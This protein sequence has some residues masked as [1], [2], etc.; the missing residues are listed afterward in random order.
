[1]AMLPPLILELKSR[2][3]EVITDLKGVDAAVSKTEAAVNSSASGIE[4]G[5]NRV[6]AAGKIVGVG[7]LAAGLVVGGVSLKMATDFQ[8]HMTL[9]QTAAGETKSGVKVVSDG[10]LN[11]AGA[12]GTSIDQLSDGAYVIE[13]AG[14]RGAAAIDVLRAASE[15]AKAENVDLATSTNALTS[16]MMSYHLRASDAV[17]TENELVAAS[18]QAKTTM[19]A[20][21][22]AL[23]T[24]I[25]VAS[26][27][28]IGFDQVG[29]AIATLTQHGTSADE[30]TQELANTIRNLQSPNAVA[31][32]A[33]QQLG[34][35]SVDVS[36]K[37]GQRGL[38]GTIDLVYDAIAKKMGPSGLVVVDTMKKSAAAS[39][40]LQ[41]MLGKMP[42]QLQQLSQSYLDGKVGL[43]DYQKSVKGMDNTSASMGLQFLSV[44]KNAD[45]FNNMI[46]AGNPAALTFSGYLKQVMGGATG[47][48]T[49][50]MLGGEN[51]AG[52]KSRVEDVSNAAKHGGKDISTWAQTQKNLSVQLDQAKEAAAAMGV[53]IGTVLIPYVSQ[54]IRVGAQWMQ[55]LQKHPAVLISIASV[56][57]GVLLVAIAAYVAKITWAAAQ[58]VVSFARMTAA[59]VVWIAKQTASA[60]ES[61]AIWSMYAGEWIATQ[62][63]AA[64]EWVGLWLTYGPAWIAEQATSVGESIAL[65]GM[66]AADW[67][68]A[69]AS[70]VAESVALWGMFAAEWVAKQSVSVAESVALW[71]MYA[72]Q[73][74][75]KQATA[76]A[77]GTAQWAVFYARWVAQAA[78]G[79]ARWVAAQSVAFAQATAR[80]AAFA[81]A[82]VAQGAGQAA[83][84]VASTA[85]TVA[86]LAVQTAALIAQ[87]APIV[88]SAA[89]MGIATAAQWAWNV[90]MDAN[91]IGIVILA[92]VALIAAIVLVATHW[93]QITSFLVSAWQA[94]V[95][96]FQGIG[97]TLASW[98]SDFWNSSIGQTVRATFQPAIDW[99]VNTFQSVVGFFQSIGADIAAGWNA[100]WSGLGSIVQA[101]FGPVISFIQGAAS[102]I[103][104]IIGG[105]SSAINGIS[106]A[107]SS[108][109]ST[110]GGV[111]GGIHL[112]SFDVGGV[113]PGAM[114]APIPILA[115]GGEVMLSNDMLAGRAPIPARAQQA[116]GQSQMKAGGA[117][118]VK[119]QTVQVYATTNASPQQIASA[120]GWELRRMG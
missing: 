9:L 74:I 67:I 19:Q 36:S 77:A 112:P 39:Q 59:T 26:A 11:L 80:G 29:G 49:A 5:F 41:A 33:M 92:I 110:V 76:I 102:T 83:A 87:K 23:S 40:D 42:P 106:S 58:S 72:G 32:Q 63:R 28:G 57:G 1:M 85:R 75:A 14:Y 51:M 43:M 7:L 93:Q 70:S 100:M 115:H 117:P 45:G 2:A 25:P 108:V 84:W 4:R 111:L 113:I 88:A 78:A 8:S 35:D 71:G 17:R 64:V 89:I 120:A 73:W 52:F 107:A 101:A 105:I 31:S 30:A 10:I 65:W 44:A 99:A 24:V 13:K 118:S 66:Y 3:G 53:R 62:S 16:V 69:Q 119:Q 47:L 61:V 96:F 56:I 20:Y 79:A 68:A 54:A 48:N 22:G 81:A 90:A 103:S 37:L 34:L 95:S 91:P 6:A 55:G 21:A 98:W 109:A 104:N 18:G 27:A 97:A 12:T 46:K 86:A 50:L 116:L 94:V 38:T 82:A 60:A 114:N 15:G